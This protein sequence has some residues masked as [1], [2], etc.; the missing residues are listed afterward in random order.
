M[1]VG[2][3]R[4]EL[5]RVLTEITGVCYPPAGIEQTNRSLDKRKRVNYDAY[6]WNA[7]PSGTGAVLS[8]KFTMKQ[9]VEAYKLDKNAV[10]VSRQ[11]VNVRSLNK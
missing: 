10:E 7:A 6:Y 5:A 11:S 3:I 4:V 2:Q 8:S 9:V 1:R